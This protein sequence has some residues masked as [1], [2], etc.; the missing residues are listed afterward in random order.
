LKVLTILLLLLGA[1]SIRAQIAVG[2]QAPALGLTNTKGVKVNISD[3]KGKVVLI[4]FWATWCPPCRAEIPTLV[5]WQSQYKDKGLQIVGITVPPTNRPQVLSFISRNKMRYPVLFGTTK[6]RSLFTSS[7][8]MP[9]SVVLDPDG[10]VVAF[11]EGIVYED[12]F[13]DKVLE[14][15]NKL[16]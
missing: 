8:A 3:F 7:S 9:F 10:K 15:L 11:I 14:L 12:E 6:T 2:D 1:L 5:K 4:N 16:K 13:N